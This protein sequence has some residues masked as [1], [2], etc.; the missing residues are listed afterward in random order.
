MDRTA[1]RR[2]RIAEL[3]EMAR[4]RPGAYRARVTALAL[5]GL[6]YRVLVA[7]A[8]VAVPAVLTL[9]IY[10]TRWIV[11]F[12]IVFLLL[13]GVSWFPP[14]KLA[15]RRLERHEAPA[16]FEALESLQRAVNAPALHG[17][18][19]D[20][21]FNA[22]AVQ[23]PRLGL[24]GWHKRVLTLGVPLLAALS[25][26]Q[27]LAVVGHELGH[28]SRSHGRFGHWIYRIRQSWENLYRNLGQED[29]GIGSAVNQFYRWFVPRFSVY[30]FALARLNEY[31][32]DA[33]SALASG[34]RS[35]A[36]ALTAVHVFDSYLAERFWPSLWRG[37]LEQPT[38]PANVYARLALWVKQAP[39]EELAAR[40]QQALQRT[41]DLVDT[42][43]SLA[44]R[45]RALQAD[46]G[47]VAP[48]AVNAGEALLGARWAQALQDAGDDWL[49]ANAQAWKEQH[50]RLGAHARRYA[51]LRAQAPEALPLEERLELAHLVHVIDGAAAALAHWRALA[52]SEP[53]DSRV[54][55]GYGRVL[56]ELRSQ[57]AF[58]VLGQLARRDEGYACAAFEAMKE[59]ALAL[60]DPAR[61]DQ[62]N[63]ALD[64]AARRVAAAQAEL[65][66]AI[67][68]AGFEA[69]RLSPHA[70]GVLARQLGADEAIRAAYLVGVRRPAGS[71]FAGYLLVIRLDPAPMT[72]RG[73]TFV[74]V[75]E[76]A[77]ALAD[78]LLEPRELLW[79]R[80]I[81]TTEA[82]DPELRAALHAVPDAVL[83]NLLPAGEPAAETMLP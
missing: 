53:G 54:L 34:A 76:R 60:G 75:C 11:G 36:Q 49:R 35:A 79:V 81:Y 5:I 17:V 38:P 52:A 63:T 77:S 58:P 25:R 24:F 51:E 13:F 45:L 80:N 74:Q 6:S 64:D 22:S 65:E 62:C 82:M 43:P 70:R 66:S 41:S 10:P 19:L 68:N 55:L 9:A 3:E 23:F 50:Q 16:L 56:A 14:P 29:S 37:A 7:F 39:P 44:E 21:D 73:E 27:L 61:A 42:H 40:R 83:F 2:A 69:P 1:A 26:E 30:S 8:F 57:D 32:A 48:P 71:P 4:R 72:R 15:G 47:P 67:N 12:A 20:G 78:A 33:D 31:E 46:E 28:F 18:R 59:L